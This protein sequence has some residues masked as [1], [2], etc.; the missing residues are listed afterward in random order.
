MDFED[1]IKEECNCTCSG[2]CQHDHCQCGHCNCEKEDDTFQNKRD[3][4]PDLPR[5]VWDADDF[6]DWD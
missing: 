4:Y 2:E 6:A 3:Y 5:M 1:N